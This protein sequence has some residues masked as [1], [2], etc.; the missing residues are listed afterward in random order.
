MA[1]GYKGVG[2]VN[3]S[4]MVRMVGNGGNNG[5]MVKMVGD[6]LGLTAT[7]FQLAEAV[8]RE[9]GQEEW[10]VRQETQQV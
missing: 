7:G 6:K 2:C 10:K 9:L 4:E 3:R 1:T 8:N 5:E